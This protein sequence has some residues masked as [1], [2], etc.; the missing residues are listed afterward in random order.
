ML[1]PSVTW[2][3]PGFEL[4]LVRQ[5]RRRSVEPFVIRVAL[6]VATGRASDRTRSRLGDHTRRHVVRD[7]EFVPCLLP[8]PLQP[9]MQRE[10]VD[11]SFIEFPR[12][13]DVWYGS[14]R[15]KS[16]RRVP[17]TARRCVIG[18]RLTGRW[19]RWRKCAMTERGGVSRR[20][21]SGIAEERNG[22]ERGNQ[23]STERRRR[24]ATRINERSAIAASPGDK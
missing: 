11:F 4:R 19:A 12:L 17:S 24:T 23:I 13:R 1:Y 22:F 2:R 18:F 20:S 16:A 14:C 7:G 21:A 8:L 3:C 6:T 10:Q 15:S 9:H 5:Q